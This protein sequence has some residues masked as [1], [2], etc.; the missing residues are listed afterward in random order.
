MA[1]ARLGH[2][3]ACPGCGL[4]LPACT[5]PTHAYVGASPACWELYQGISA[6]RDLRETG[7][8]L[9]RLVGDTY[10]A[11]HPGAHDRRALQSVA[12]HLMGLC[13]LLEGNGEDRRLTPVLGRMPPRRTLDLHWLTPPSPNGR[14]T[15]ADVVASGPEHGPSVEAWAKDVWRAW[16]P[17]HE[18]VRGWLDVACV[19][20]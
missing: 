1:G 20:S 3:A 15:I 9:R 17:H 12:V 5:G 7:A 2:N 10:A 11:Q 4:L 19:P 16:A 6:G 14:L 8:R 13:V 18:T